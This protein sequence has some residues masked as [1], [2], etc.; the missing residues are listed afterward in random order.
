MLSIININSYRGENQSFTWSLGRAVLPVD[1]ASHYSYPVLDRLRIPPSSPFLLLR[2]ATGDAL[3]EAPVFGEWSRSVLLESSALAAGGLGGGGPGG[4]GGFKGGSGGGGPGGG[5]G[6][7]GPSPAEP[8]DPP[9]P[10]ERF[11]EARR[12]KDSFRFCTRMEP[13]ARPSLTPRRRGCRARCRARP[14]C[15]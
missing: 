6:L 7:E 2:A 9:W 8:C 15:A 4:G 5:G 13:S 3:G 11:I 1:P 14:A 10:A 12:P